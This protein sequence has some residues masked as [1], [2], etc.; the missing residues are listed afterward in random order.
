MSTA[1]L[2]A[3]IHLRGNINFLLSKHY[4]VNIYWIAL[5]SVAFYDFMASG[6]RSFLVPTASDKCRHSRAW[7]GCG[8]L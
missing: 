7:A 6:A 2:Q 3:W 8:G 5:C 4:T 1:L